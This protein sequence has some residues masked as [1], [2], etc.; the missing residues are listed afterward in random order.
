M[1]SRSFREGAVGLL[2]LAGISFFVVIVVWLKDI[3][4]G[5]QSY[6]LIIEFDNAAG[7]KEGSAVFYRG[8][9][10]GTV[11]GMKA[12]SNFVSVEVSIKPATLKMPRNVAV[13]V[14]QTGLIGEASLSIYPQ[15]DLPARLKGPGPLDSQCDSSVILCD[16]DKVTGNPPIN[17][18]ALIRS[19]VRIADLVTSTDFQDQMGSAVDNLTDTTKEI[20]QLSK[21]AASLARSIEEQLGTFGETARSIGRNADVLGEVAVRTGGAI[22]GTSDAATRTLNGATVTLGEV[23]QLLASNKGSITATLTN[24]QRTSDSLRAFIGDISPALNGGQ[25]TSILKN[26]EVLSVHAAAAAANIRTLT[27]TATEP[28][29]L[30]ELRQTL[31]AAR[32]TLQNVE[33]ITTDLDQ[34]TGD[35]DFRKNLQNIIRGLGQLFSSMEML[36]YQVA[37]AENAGTRSPQ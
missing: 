21:D 17:Y 22:A 34:L 14:D 32:G 31:T 3:T 1:R 16:G 11:E 19:M 4:L 10:V 5:Q 8:V 36:Q 35:P 9:P 6:R 12:T 13:E 18:G 29:A 23:N 33:R 26:L 15:E 7:M 28:D 20:Q 37:L 2:A 24:I 30:L 27:A 25:G